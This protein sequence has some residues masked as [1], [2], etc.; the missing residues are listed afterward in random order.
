MNKFRFDDCLLSRA[1]ST[2]IVKHQSNWRIMQNLKSKSAFKRLPIYYQQLHHIP[3]NPQICDSSDCYLWK[4]TFL[5]TRIIFDNSDISMCTIIELKDSGSIWYFISSPG[6]VHNRGLDN[7]LFYKPW[8]TINWVPL[9]PHPTS[10]TSI[11]ND[12]TNHVECY[13]NSPL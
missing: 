2:H 10:C 9:L 5:L 1:W 4:H 11:F 13:I 7:S 3:V 12:V 6:N 8:S